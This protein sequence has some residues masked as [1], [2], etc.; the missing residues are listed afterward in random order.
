MYFA[1]LFWES[2]VC[3]SYITARILDHI[4]GVTINEMVQYGGPF[5]LYVYAFERHFYQLFHMIT[6]CPLLF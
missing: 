2:F 3:M 5:D 4:R 6:F 1:Q